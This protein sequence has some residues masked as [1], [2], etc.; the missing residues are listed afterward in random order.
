[1]DISTL[2]PYF[3][4]LG[5]LGLF[6]LALVSNAIPYSTIPYLVVIASSILARLRGLDLLIAILTLSAGA[7]MGKLVVYFIGRSLGR[8]EK[9]K[10]FTWSSTK[11]FSKHKKSVF[12]LIFLVAALPLPDDVFYIP[13]ATA[14]YSIIYFT[15]ALFLGKLVIT[16]L[17]ALY[18]ISLGFLLEETA[19]LPVYISIPVMI[20]VTIVLTIL[21]NKID[22]AGVENTY[23]EKGALHAF[24]Y[25]L[26]SII[27][28]L[29]ITPLVK[30]ITILEKYF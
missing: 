24:I 23:I 12:T 20:A 14:R 1:M 19:K 27:K 18:G 10:N 17:T 30:L 15:I 11:F 25:L 21:V 29:F 26:K 9:I 2:M 4:E 22:W 28:L 16:I 3:R 5:A 7:T 6:L 8:I 13:I